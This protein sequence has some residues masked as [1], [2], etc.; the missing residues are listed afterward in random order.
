[1]GLPEEKQKAALVSSNAASARVPLYR[2]DLFQ[3]V[4]VVGMTT[5]IDLFAL[6]VFHIGFQTEIPRQ[7]LVFLR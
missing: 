1:M 7:R 5:E 4:V 6:H 2:A 3:V